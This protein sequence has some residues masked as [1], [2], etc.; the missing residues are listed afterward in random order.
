MPYGR[1]ARAAISLTLMHASPSNRVPD[2]KSDN[3]LPTFSITLAY[4]VDC[5]RRFS[6]VLRKMLVAKRQVLGMKSA[7]SVKS[8]VPRP[9]PVPPPY[10]IMM[11]VKKIKR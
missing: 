8:L 2:V 10:L 3:I 5:P 6:S 1:D 7:V 9:L 11:Q 4:G